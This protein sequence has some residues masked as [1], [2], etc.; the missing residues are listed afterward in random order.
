VSTAQA[1][2]RVR[3]AAVEP[4]ARD[5]KLY[6]LAP[7]D[8]P[9]LAP[10]T[11]GAH[12]DVH[13]HGGQVRQYSLLLGLDDRHY[14][15]AVKRDAAG[16]GGSHAMHEVSAGQMLAIGTPRN[17]FPLAEDG[18]PSV[19]LAGGIGI[20]PIWSMLLRLEALGQPYELHYACRSRADVLFAADIARRPDVHLHL[21]DEA[22]GLLDVASACSRAP[23]GVHLYCCGPA[24]MLAAFKTATSTRPPNLVHWE[25]FGGAAGPLRHGGF[26]LR[27]ARSQRTL[28]V[29]PGQRIVDVMRAAG[30]PVAVSC[31]QGICGACET[32]VLEGRPDHG[33]QVLS[34]A[35]REAGSTMMVC[36][37][38]SQDARLVLDL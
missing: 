16:R 25:D 29:A 37:G 15:I 9:L 11:A 20:T 14:V 8:P 23:E 34:P 2:Q 6:R 32:T 1:L 5:V 36:C 30:L 17:H 12:V 26:E 3:V 27:L 18:R 35:E 28:Q 38:G 21:D 33:C 4:V 31:E 22:G 7:S 19:L 13:L 24:P 10:A